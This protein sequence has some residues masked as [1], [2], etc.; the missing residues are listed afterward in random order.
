MRDDAVAFAAGR[1]ARSAAARSAVALRAAAA[2][3]SKR[4]YG[5]AVAN[6]DGSR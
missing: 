4:E 5:N 3:S 6:G 2:R 1:C